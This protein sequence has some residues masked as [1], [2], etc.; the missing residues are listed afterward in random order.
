[1]KSYHSAILFISKCDLIGERAL[2]LL[3]HK[4]AF[5]RGISDTVMMRSAHKINEELIHA[6]KG[7]T[8]IL[9]GD[10]GCAKHLCFRQS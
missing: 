1:V 10:R 3:Q 8:T 6:V 2:A 9:I 5:Y 4:L 7:K